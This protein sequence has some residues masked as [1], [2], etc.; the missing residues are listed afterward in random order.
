LKIAA[1]AD[2]HTRVW[3]AERLHALVQDAAGDADVL[4]IGGDL[5]DLGHLEQVEVLLEVLETCS[6][7]ILATLGNHDYESGNV[8]ELSRLIGESNVYLLD[9]SS[10]VIDGVGFSGVKGFCGGFDGNLANSFGEELFKAWV[11]EG[12][13]EA[14]A[15]KNELQN[16]ETER[17]VAVLHYAPVRATVEGEPPEIHA[18]LGTSHLARA[19]D[20]GSATVAFHGHAHHGSFKGMTRGG[21]PVF[22]VSLPVLKH[23]GFRQPYYLVQ[24]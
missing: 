24:V 3:D 12:V 21:V 11:T 9:R 18:F 4:A 14:E 7:P 6:I 2:I 15:L 22:N 10:I 5:T 13:L 1:T 8:A 19:L 17:R 16:L 20:E 23:E